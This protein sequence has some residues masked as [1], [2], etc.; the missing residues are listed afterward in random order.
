MRDRFVAESR[1]AAALDDP[2]VIPIYDADEVDGELF[3]AMKY[4]QG[5]DLATLIDDEG[6][7]EL[8]KTLS[9]LEQVESRSEIPVVIPLHQAV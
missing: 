2:H 6:P 7:Q 4:V 3:I 9:I 8:R 1:M 5:T